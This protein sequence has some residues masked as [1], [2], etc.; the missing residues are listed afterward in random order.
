MEPA[1]VQ[2]RLRAAGVHVSVRGKAVRISPH[3]Y[4]TERDLQALVDVLLSP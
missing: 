1:A 4:N 3:E 2:E